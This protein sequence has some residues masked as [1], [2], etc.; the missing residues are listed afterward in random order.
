[1]T[2]AANTV[3]PKREWINRRSTNIF[4]D[5]VQGWVTKERF[6]QGQNASTQ[7]S[8]QELQFLNL[9]LAT[10]E[11]IKQCVCLCRYE[12]QQA[13]IQEELARVAHNE[14]EAARQ[15]ITRAVKRERA[16]TR[17]E[18][19]KAKQLV[20]HFTILQYRSRTVHANA[21]WLYCT[22]RH[23]CVIQRCKKKLRIIIG[24]LAHNL[25]TNKTV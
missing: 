3:A 25:A 13:I 9:D 5:G 19:E 6:E 12:R 10:G 7:C 1:M 15:D 8:D 21:L 14:R 16:Q 2:W 24:M 17:Q 11:K 18:S 22:F 20:R 4:L 23:E